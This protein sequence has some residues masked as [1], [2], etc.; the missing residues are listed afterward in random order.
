MGTN[1]GEDREK[2]EALMGQMSSNYCNFTS[3]PSSITKFAQ[4]QFA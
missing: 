4:V 2:C 3:I 1:P